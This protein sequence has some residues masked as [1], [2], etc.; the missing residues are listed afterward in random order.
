M[1][2]S[3]AP[4]KSHMIHDYMCKDGLC[5]LQECCDC[6]SL[7]L[8]FRSEGHHCKAHQYLGF[9]CRHVFQ[10]CCEGEESRAGDQD[11][12]HSVRERPALDSTP[13]PKKGTVNTHTHKLN[14]LMHCMLHAKGGV[15]GLEHVIHTG[16]LPGR[17]SDLNQRQSIFFILAVKRKHC[18][19]IPQPFWKMARLIGLPEQSIIAPTPLYC[20]SKR[21]SA[22]LP[23]WHCIKS[24]FSKPLCCW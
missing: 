15:V 6:C 8:Q 22:C 19:K 12:W 5:D 4:L 10:T 1:D 24:F 7:G 14:M 3:T 16:A 21:D 11:V 17:S 2:H 18:C 23:V 13:L 9:H 20:N